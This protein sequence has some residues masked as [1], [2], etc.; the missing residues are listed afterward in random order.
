[1]SQ[2]RTWEQREAEAEQARA[3]LESEVRRHVEREDGLKAKC[4]A[5]EL[6]LARINESLAQTRAT[7]AEEEA[8]RLAAEGR[9]EELSQLQI[10]AGRELAER[11][12]REKQLRQKLEE[13]AKRLSDC[14]A[15]LSAV[16]SLVGDKTRSLQ[17]AEARVAVLAEKESRLERELVL[18]QQ[19][20]QSLEAK[21][22][23]LAATHQAAAEELAELRAQA[24]RGASSEERLRR[25]LEAQVIELQRSKEE[26]TRVLQAAHEREEARQQ[27]IN[28]LESQFKEALAKLTSL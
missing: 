6:H 4:A 19:T 21:A 7:V 15:S 13:G 5:F 25:E 17:A 20:S 9:V 10:A 2:T 23:A 22:N 26:I 27:T 11:A 18:S 16:E 28:A 24:A 8:S 1:V 3:L 14:E 12:R